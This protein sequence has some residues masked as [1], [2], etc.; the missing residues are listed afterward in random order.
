[1]GWG[2]GRGSRLLLVG[3]AVN[4]VVK[5]TRASG[6]A[7]LTSAGGRPGG[8]SGAAETLHCKYER[9]SSAIGS[10][11]ISLDPKGSRRALETHVRVRRRTGTCMHAGVRFASGGGR[12]SVYRGRNNSVGPHVHASARRWTGVGPHVHALDRRWAAFPRVGQAL[13]RRWTACPR[14]GEALDRR[15]TAL[16][17]VGQALD[18]RWTAFPR[19]GQALDRRWTGVGPHFHALDRAHRLAFILL[20]RNGV[21]GWPRF[22]LAYRLLLSPLALLLTV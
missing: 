3:S 5:A 16:P 22:A 9:P 13:D 11:L 21:G 20:K 4:S 19:V 2:G 12:F 14:D 6:V 8:P 10:G 7:P 15:W 17:R 18:R 1:M